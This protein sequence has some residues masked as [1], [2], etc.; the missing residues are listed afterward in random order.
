MTNELRNKIENELKRV[1][2]KLNMN[3]KSI[4]ERTA[5][6]MKMLAKR[7]ATE[8]VVDNAAMTGLVVGVATRSSDE[9]NVIKG[10]K[11]YAYAK[12]QVIA[13][14]VTDN[15]AHLVLETY[16]SYEPRGWGDELEDYISENKRYRKIVEDEIDDEFY[17]IRYR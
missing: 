5:G 6:V 15:D 11:E 13:M 7:E 4:Q 2:T 3:D 1:Y 8:I 10:G 9:N 17:T 14:V 12:M 16:D